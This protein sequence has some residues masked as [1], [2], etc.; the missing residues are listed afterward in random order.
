ME[1]TIVMTDKFHQINLYLIL[2][3]SQRYL[4][5]RAPLSLKVMR[6]FHML[7]CC[8]AV[9]DFL[10]LILDIVCFALPEFSK[11]YQ[12]GFLLYAIPYVIPIT[13]VKLFQVSVFTQ[14]KK[15]LIYSGHPA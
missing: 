7:M 11:E 1:F 8:L 9:Y 3:Y 14:Q 10:H 15:I 13:Q 2:T 12:K 6:N 5:I 4:Q